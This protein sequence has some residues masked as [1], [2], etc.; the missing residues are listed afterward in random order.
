[1]VGGEIAASHDVSRFD[2]VMAADVI[3][4]DP[5]V[6][7]AP[8]IEGIKDYW[9]ALFQSFPDLNLEVDVFLADEEYVSL[10]YRLS[11]T[12]LGDYM[13]HGPTGKFFEVRSLQVGRFANGRMVERWGSTDVRGI[14]MQLGVGT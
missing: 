13:G 14:L 5:D 4:H 1:M 3:D 8:G 7:Q 6:G 9:R 11:G 10:I 2:E 12:H